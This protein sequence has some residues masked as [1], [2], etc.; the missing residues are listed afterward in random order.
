[1]MHHT[2]YP[3]KTSDLVTDIFSPELFEVLQKNVAIL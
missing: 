3:D 2:E 1:L